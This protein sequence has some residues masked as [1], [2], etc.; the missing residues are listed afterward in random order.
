[1]GVMVMPRVDDEVA[2][3]IVEAA[4]RSGRFE[5][6][7][8]LDGNRYVG[9]VISGDVDPVTSPGDTNDYSLI[10]RTDNALDIKI[11][12]SGDAHGHSGMAAIERS[13]VGPPERSTND[14]SR[15]EML[16]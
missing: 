4:E 5:A 15:F 1:M 6:I 9:D 16:N 14:I 13:T 7:V 2:E 12:L 8:E 10:V 11:F 3:K